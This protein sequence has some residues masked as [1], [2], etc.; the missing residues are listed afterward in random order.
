MRKLTLVYVAAFA[1]V[2]AIP[3]SVMATAIEA[4]AGVSTVQAGN[5]KAAVDA[6]VGLEFKLERFF[7]IMPE[8]NFQALGFDTGSYSTTVN[9]I[10]STV[11]TSRTYYTFIPLANLRFNIPM[12]SEDTPLVQPYITAGLGFGYSLY[13]Q[14]NPDANDKATGFMYQGM[15]GAKFNMGMIADGSASATNLL[16]EVGYRGGQLESGGAKADWNGVVIR[17]G[18]NYGF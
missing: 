9:G 3:G 2:L 11:T 10:T 18:V 14:K 16:V 4:K 6:A 12:G 15:V 7:S 1:A 5:S 17:A 8:V 13:N